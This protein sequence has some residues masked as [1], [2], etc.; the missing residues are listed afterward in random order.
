MGSLVL[1]TS[2]LVYLDTPIFV[3]TVEH[4]ST[5]SPLLAPLWQSVAAGDLEIAASEL[6]LMETLI[7][8]IRDGDH[9]LAARYEQMLG[10]PS[11]RFLPIN[12]AILRE[13]ANLRA[14]VKALRT[15]D[16]LHAATALSAGAAMFLTN[17]RDFRAVP[18]L[19]VTILKDVLAT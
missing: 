16:A 15:P 12:Q 3:Y 17:D 1:P 8:P 6:C 19:P 14:T 7:R 9:P 11:L 4:H 18:N 2:G 10:Q 5:Y 13:A